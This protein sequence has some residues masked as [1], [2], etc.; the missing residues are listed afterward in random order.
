MLE[1]DFAD[2]VAAEPEL[3]ARH[4][5]EA[6]LLEKAVPWWLR[7]GERATER[8]A[9]LEAIA[10][11]K[12]GLEVLERLPES[13]ARD[14][15]E[16]LLQAALI[17]PFS[18]N[19]GYA[20]AALERAARRA[21]ELGGRI[22]ADLPAQLQAVWARGWLAD[23]HMFRGELRTGLAIAEETLGLAERLGDPLLLGHAHYMMGH[24]PSPFG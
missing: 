9:N 11:L 4:L 10:H 1:A 15:Q 23:V 18:A 17:A 2:R 20:S 13:R 7:A 12:R 24:A 8:S 14:E 6:G 5:T 21:V 22:A 19:E 16:L 3:L